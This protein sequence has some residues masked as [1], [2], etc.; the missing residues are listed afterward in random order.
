MLSP[1]VARKRRK[2][3]GRGRELELSKTNKRAAQKI[4]VGHS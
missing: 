1:V 4:Y 2:K 3:K